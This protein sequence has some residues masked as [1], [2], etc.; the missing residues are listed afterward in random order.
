MLYIKLKEHVQ[1]VAQML[2]LP[3]AWEGDVFTPPHT[4][5]LRGKI[6]FTASS[7]AT[8][9]AGGLIKTDGYIE[10]SIVAPAGESEKVAEITDAVQAVF[11]RGISLD[12]T[13]G[14]ATLGLSALGSILCEGSRISTA[15]TIPFWAF[16]LN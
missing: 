15:V 13:K 16:S 5:H 10:L 3:L 9:G 2:S 14:T 7:P 11:P 12:F 1:S 4:P 8:L 6:V